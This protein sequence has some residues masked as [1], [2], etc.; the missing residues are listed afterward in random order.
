MLNLFIH[1]YQR[2]HCKDVVVS[3]GFSADVYSLFIYNNTEIHRKYQANFTSTSGP[4]A[5]SNAA[6][7]K[8][9]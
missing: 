9:L 8:K 2:Y 1:L 7:N 3:C 5:A 4:T 6:E